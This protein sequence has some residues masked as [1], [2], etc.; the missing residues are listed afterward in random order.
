MHLT[1]VAPTDCGLLWEVRQKVS[2]RR[3]VARRKRPNVVI[4]RANASPP[5]KRSEAVRFHV[6]PMRDVSWLHVCSENRRVIE[7]YLRLGIRVVREIA[8]ASVV[9]DYSRMIALK[10]SGTI[11]RVVGDAAFTSSMND[12]ARRTAGSCE[13]A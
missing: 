9:A 4:Q 11:T 1:Q 8:A 2:F 3:H 6:L 10:Y 13:T 5:A 12:C 7:L